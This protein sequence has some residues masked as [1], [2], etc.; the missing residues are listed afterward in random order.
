M[1]AF[2]PKTKG[3]G[4]NPD[5]LM[6]IHIPNELPVHGSVTVEQRHRL[7]ASSRFQSLSKAN[8]LTGFFYNIY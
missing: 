2:V 1:A 3:G 8:S 6:L 4:G 5:G 7:A